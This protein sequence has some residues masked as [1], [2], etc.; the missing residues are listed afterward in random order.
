MGVVSSVKCVSV[1]HITR[2][3]DYISVRV[4]ESGVAVLR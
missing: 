3:L 4:K 1:C 2:V